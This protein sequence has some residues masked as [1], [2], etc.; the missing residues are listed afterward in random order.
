MKMDEWYGKKVVVIGAARQGTALA[1]YLVGMGALVILNDQR[2]CEALAEVRYSLADL[3]TAGKVIW[4]CGGHPLELLDGADL[5]CP[6]GGV[7]LT[8]PL[9]QEA[10]RRGIPL[11]N[12]SQIFLD[13]CPCRTVGITGSAGKTTTTSLLGQMAS[14]AFGDD[15]VW[16]GGNIGIPLVSVLDRIR[17]DHLAV[18]ELSSFQLEDHDPYGE[19]VGCVE[20]NA[21]PP[22]SRTRWKPIPLPKRIIN[23]SS[24][25]SQSS[26]R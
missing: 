12:D 3:V 17:S 11:S 1:R 6:S 19:C 7:P 5:L 18:L 13:A 2:P 21:Q 23:S 4:V 22:R 20:C 24:L 14:A 9:I 8:L 25:A 26:W 10:L 15:K 16:V